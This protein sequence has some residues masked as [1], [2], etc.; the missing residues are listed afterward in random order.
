MPGGP[1]INDKF[2]NLIG[3]TQDTDS[4]DLYEYLGDSWGIVFMHP[5]DFTPV[6][7]TELGTAAKMEE[8]FATRNVKLCGFSCNDSTSHKAWIQDI[9]AVTSGKVTFPL[10]C[11][12]TREHSV[13][14]GILDQTNKDSKSLPM[15]V[16]SVYILQPTHHTIALMMT[17]PASTGRNF[18]EILRVVDSLQRTT[19]KKTATPANWKPGEDVIVNFPLTDAD[20]DETFGKDGWRT[21]EVPSE[22]GK[23]LPK[24][25]LRYTKDSA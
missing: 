1:T 18:D 12:P 7:T 22:A 16:R 24:H 10:F 25:Y 23:D 20:A 5:G 21:V 3:S 6:C 11:D 14:L 8:D 13:A 9:L 19:E 15:T 17:Y 2:P 4:F